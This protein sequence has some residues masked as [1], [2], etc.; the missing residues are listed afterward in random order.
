MNRML[1][2]IWI[3]R[4]PELVLA[5]ASTPGLW[6]EWH[7][8]SLRLDPGAE[9]PLGRGETFEEDIRTAGRDDHLSWV[10]EESE[11]GRVWAA[12][13]LSRN[14]GARILVRY[15]VS[16]SEGGTEFQRDLEYELPGIG[17]RVL[18]ALF[19][20]RRIDAES[21]LSLL[22]LKQRVE[23]NARRS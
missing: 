21:R 8:A 14:N 5:Y 15:R 17:L 6:P 12:R 23:A 16:A 4:P 10:V 13:A 19:L 18:N 7:P 1:H 20:R 3:A 9:R 2:R 11:P 22:Q